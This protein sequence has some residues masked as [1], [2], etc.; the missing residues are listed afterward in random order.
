[1]IPVE[2]LPETAVVE[3]GEF[4]FEAGFIPEKKE[5]MVGE[6]I[7]TTFYVKNIGTQPIYLETGGDHRSVRSYRFSFSAIDQDG[8]AARDPHPNPMHFGGTQGPPPTIE[9]GGTYSERLQL[10]KWLAFDRPGQY[11]VR[12]ART[13]Q[14]PA[15]TEF[16][17]DYEL[18]H[19]VATTFRLKVVPSTDPGLAARIRELDQQLRAE[20]DE[21]NARLTAQLMVETGDVRI[22]PS[23]LWAAER[24]SG[25]Y[26][27]LHMLSCFKQDPR[28]IA[29]YRDALRA[30]RGNSRRCN[31]ARLM[32]ESGNKEFVPDLLKAFAGE[33]DRFVLTAAAQALGKLG[34]PEAADVLKKHREHAD[35]RLRLAVEQALVLCGDTLDVSRFQTMIR[36][37]DEN[38]SAAAHFVAENAGDAATRILAECL[39]FDHP[40]AGVGQGNHDK[41]PASRNWTLVMYIAHA[42]GPK[43]SYHKVHNRPATE[44]ENEENRGALDTIRKKLLL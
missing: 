15:T 40:E 43:V 29:L 36:S 44:Q 21:N 26:W 27:A 23:L 17:Q 2:D 16:T 25:G 38:W 10:A 5:V 19:S 28:V 30:S 35:S 42:G 6:A 34:Q 20:K 31:A 14:F 18:V 24:W 1:M 9:P 37:T 13:L 3:Q 7:Y 11:T 32:A 33:D 22:I 39:D 8:N 41:S 12:C 4:K